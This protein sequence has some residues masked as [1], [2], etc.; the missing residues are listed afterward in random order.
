[1]VRF[2]SERSRATQLSADMTSFSDWINSYAL[3]D[4]QLGGAKFTWFDHKFPPTLSHIPALVGF[5]CPMI[6]LI[7]IRRCIR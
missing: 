2:P 1:M 7:D 6:G 3:I 5:W 4:L